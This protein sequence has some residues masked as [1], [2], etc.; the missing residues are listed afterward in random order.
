M[1]F[2]VS[3]VIPF[4]RLKAKLD[5]LPDTAQEKSPVESASAKNIDLKAPVPV[6]VWVPKVAVAPPTSPVRPTFPLSSVSKAKRKSLLFV[7]PPAT[8]AQ[9][10]RPPV[11]I[12]TKYISLKNPEPPK[13][14][15]DTVSKV[16]EP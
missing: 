15:T 14:F 4:P 10:A 8:S 16:N 3:N 1:F 11:V 9:S 7:V 2:A 12:R 5:P 6:M 13:L